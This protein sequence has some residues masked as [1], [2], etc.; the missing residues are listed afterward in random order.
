MAEWKQKSKQPVNWLSLRAL[1]LIEIEKIFYF[2]SFSSLRMQTKPISAAGEVVQHTCTLHTTDIREVIIHNRFFSVSPFPRSIRVNFVS[3]SIS[4]KSLSPSLSL[5]FTHRS[6]SNGEPFHP[7]TNGDRE[8]EISKIT[9]L[10]WF[11]LCFT[12]NFEVCHVRGRSRGRSRG[13]ACHLNDVSDQ[14]PSSSTICAICAMYK[15][16]RYVLIRVNPIG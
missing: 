2:I 12:L 16:G 10:F 1:G 13:R 9:D 5:S 14:T 3:R 4:H 8:A 11:L 15:F 7:M 6:A